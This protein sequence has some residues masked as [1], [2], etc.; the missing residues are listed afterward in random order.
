MLDSSSLGWVWDGGPKLR[1][2]AR[3]VISPVPLG[4]HARHPG[5][6]LAVSRT[7][8]FVLNGPAQSGIS[9]FQTWIPEM[10]A[11][12][13]SVV[14]APWA[15][16]QIDPP[17]IPARL[18]PNMLFLGAMMHMQYGL[19]HLVGHLTLDNPAQGLVN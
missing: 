4:L 12:Q 13:L 19:G 9:V 11:V 5:E 8:S 18:A 6:L 1:W 17:K 14:V 16:P 3:Q 10:K 2:A 7:V 15:Y